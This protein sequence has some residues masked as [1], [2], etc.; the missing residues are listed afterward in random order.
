MMCDKLKFYEPA[1][2]SLDS[3]VNYLTKLLKKCKEST[4][5]KYKCHLISDQI[6]DKNSTL[7]KIKEMVEENRKLCEMYQQ[8]DKEVNEMK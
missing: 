5:K 8:L 7:K 4:N 2:Y 1:I 3:E 6:N